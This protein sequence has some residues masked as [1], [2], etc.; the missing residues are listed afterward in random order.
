MRSL[1][2]FEQLERDFEEVSREMCVTGRGNTRTMSNHGIYLIQTHPI[3]S[4]G[5]WDFEGV[6][7]NGC[8]M[9]AYTDEDN[10]T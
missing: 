8:I 3:L 5:G 7:I 10:K 9:L 6:T 1:T 4:E 2:E